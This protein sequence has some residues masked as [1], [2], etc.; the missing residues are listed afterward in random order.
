MRPLFHLRN[1][2][3]PFI[4]V[5]HNKVKHHKIYMLQLTGR[6]LTLDEVYLAAAG[7]LAPVYSDD[8]GERIAAAR[9][10]V[11]DLVTRGQ[12]VYGLNTGFGKLADVNVP[13]AAIGALQLNLVR[14]HA[15]GLGEPLSIPEVRAMMIL[16]ANVFALGHS[17]VTM[18]LARTLLAMVERG[19]YPRIPEKGSVGASG[20]LAPL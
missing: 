8:A 2:S 6:S 1:V 20:D 5:K 17:G 16:R 15:A 13:P 18:D 9:R 3:V 14:S 12:V 7:K 11:E 10:A 4:L 19:V